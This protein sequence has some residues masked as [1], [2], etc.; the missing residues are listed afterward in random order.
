MQPTVTEVARY[1][2]LRALD[3]TVSSVKTA[4]TVSSVKTAEP[5]EN[6]FG[7]GFPWA[8]GTTF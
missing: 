8:Q 2:C 7:Y 3:T 1:V 5:I 6:P 4:T